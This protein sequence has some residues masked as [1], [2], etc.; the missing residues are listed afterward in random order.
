MLCVNV[1]ITNALD[2]TVF[3]LKLGYYVIIDVNVRG[4]TTTLLA[5]IKSKRQ[6][7]TFTVKREIGNR[8]KKIYFSRKMRL[9]RCRM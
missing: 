9:N 4:A 5:L 3:A 2:R 8:F 7:S 1:K 6:E